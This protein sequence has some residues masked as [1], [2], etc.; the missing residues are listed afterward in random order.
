MI[1]I[2]YDPFGICKWLFTNQSA[3]RAVRNT[4]QRVTEDSDVVYTVEQLDINNEYN[5]ETGIF[6]PKQ[7]GVY[8]LNAAVGYIPDNLNEG[9]FITLG[10]EVNGNLVTQDTEIFPF[11]EGVTSV[12]TII[13]LQENDSV[14]VVI[15]APDG[16]IEGEVTRTRFEGALLVRQ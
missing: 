12:S 8:S 3:F 6:R 4:N 14:K 13:P 11:G 16:N 10:F 1:K 7:D 2:A 9:Y 5:P 15:R